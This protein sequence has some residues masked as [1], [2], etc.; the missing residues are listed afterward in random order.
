MLCGKPATI[1]ARHPNQS[2]VKTVTT[3]PLRD[4]VLE[5]CDKRGDTWAFEVQTRLYGCIAVH[6]S[7]CF[8]RFILNKELEQALES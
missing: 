1:D 3:L 4:K 8:S 6:H 5:Q 7:K 2:K